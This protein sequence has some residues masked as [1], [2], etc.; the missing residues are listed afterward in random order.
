MYIEIVQTWD[1]GLHKIRHDIPRVFES[2]MDNS[3]PQSY[4][5]FSWSTQLKCVLLNFKLS[6]IVNSFML[7]IV[8]HEHFS[9]NEHENA[10]YFYQR[11]FHAH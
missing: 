2:V 6:T 3:G 7:N 1:I 11:K 10:N 8:Q 4:K 5:T 9:A